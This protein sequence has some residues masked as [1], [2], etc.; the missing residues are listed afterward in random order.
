MIILLVITFVFSITIKGTHFSG[1]T[2]VWAPADPY[3]NASTV[4]ITIMQTYA[5][6]LSHVHC[7][8][9]VPISTS[10][11]SSGNVSLICIGNC[12][13]DGGYSARPLNILTDCISSISSL[14]MMTSQRSKNV[15]LTVGAYFTI[16]YRGGA[17]R[18]LDNSYGT[19]GGSWSIAS[20]INLR[21][22]SDGILNTSPVS[23]VVSP[24]FAVVNRTTRIK[25]PVYDVN[26]SDDIRCRWAQ[27]N[28]YIFHSYTLNNLQII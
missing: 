25:I 9:N 24:Q 2:I 23:S 27:K 12:S 18:T 6:V 13:N 10:S 5:W 16:A 1:G 19:S 11:W 3:T 22:R 15:T 17:W 14:D 4:V 28:R 21:R 26:I 7:N 20:L 8:A